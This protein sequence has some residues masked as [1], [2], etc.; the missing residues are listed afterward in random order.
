M[1]N[2]KIKRSQKTKMSVKA[3]HGTPVGGINRNLA[4][5][6]GTNQDT[7]SLL[8]CKINYSSIVYRSIVM[9]ACT[10]IRPHQGDSSFPSSASPRPH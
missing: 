4:T 7:V 9:Y 10:T 8:H 2:Y 3:E 5:F 6:V 1:S